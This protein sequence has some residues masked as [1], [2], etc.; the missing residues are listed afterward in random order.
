MRCGSGTDRGRHPDP[1]RAGLHARLAAFAAGL[2]EDAWI[3]GE[4]WNYGA[5]PGG[6]PT[7]DMLPVE[8]TGRRPAFLFSYDVHTV[9]LN[10]EA[11]ARLGVTAD[12]DELPWGRPDSR[13]R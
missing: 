1:E 6:A 10:R 5:V 11:M 8:V 12:V 7:A 13:I 3:E 4:G 9:W 2:P